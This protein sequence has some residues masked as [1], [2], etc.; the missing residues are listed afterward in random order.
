MPRFIEPTRCASCD[1]RG[2]RRLMGFVRREIRSPILAW[3]R[4]LS[5]A[6]FCAIVD[7]QGRLVSDPSSRSL[8]TIQIAG[9]D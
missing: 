3:G 8:G 7:L 4:S 2:R 5:R 6:A 1:R 9:R